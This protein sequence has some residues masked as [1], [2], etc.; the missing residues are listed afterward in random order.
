MIV[1]NSYAD[2][3]LYVDKIKYWNNDN[4][5]ITDAKFE[6]KIYGFTISR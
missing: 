4:Y 1:L 5:T 2:C 6:Y 3:R